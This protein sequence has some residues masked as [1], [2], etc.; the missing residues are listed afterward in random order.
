LWPLLGSLLLWSLLGYFF[1][2]DLVKG[3]QRLASVP[4]L[5]GLLGE[6]VLRLLSQFSVS[7]ALLLILPPLVQASALLITATVA[8]PVMLKYVA[9]RDFPQLQRRRGGRLAGSLWN[10]LAATLLYLLLW[11]LTLPL[12]L[13][14]VP[15]LLLPVLLGGWLNDRLFRYDALAEHADREEYAALGARA[16]GRFYLLGCIAALIQLVPLLN[17][18]APVYAG[19]SFVHFGCTELVRLRAGR[20]A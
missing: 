19:L 11:L 8:L 7:I 10:T 15:A 20:A 6:P 3:L 18:V 14:G 1:W 9:A 2:H 4:A 17:L 12:Y 13:F 5:Q 16:G